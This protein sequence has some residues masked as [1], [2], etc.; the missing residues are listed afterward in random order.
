MALEAGTY[1]SDLVATNPTSSDAKSQGDDHLRLIK[2]TLLSTFPNVAGEVTPTHTELNFVDG[3][4]SAIQTQLDA[5]AAATNG[6]LTNPTVTNYV[7]T[8]HAATGNTAIDLANGTVQKITTN[9][10]NT[11]TLP[12][13]VA[14]KSFVVIVA[15][16][17][18]HT[19]TWA[20]GGT[21]KW[22]GGS[23]PTQTK[24]NGKFDIF[25]FLQD[26]TN[27]YGT[28]FGLGF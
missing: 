18:T 5:K 3:V 15:Y 10:N 4:T 19:V 17:G 22:A 7:E 8:L 14:G 6:A 13:S 9:G 26:G 20:G 12:S 21:I 23:E 16:G 11:I 28:V 2:S 1:I 27:S 24:V 25:T